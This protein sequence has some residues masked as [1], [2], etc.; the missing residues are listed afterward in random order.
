MNTAGD[1]GR[2]GM[3]TR[4]TTC[5]EW[6][7]LCALV[8][9]FVWQGFLPAWGHLNT[10][11]PNYY[12]AGKLFRGGYPLERLYD[13]VWIQR[14]KDHAGIVDPPLVGYVPL[15]P[16]SGLVVAPLSSLPPL[17]AKR[18]WL[19]INLL[20]LG[21]TGH[22]LHRMTR[23][24]PR[25]IAMM[26]FLAVLPLRNNF[27]FG[28]QYLLILFLLTAAAWFYSNKRTFASGSLLAVAASLKIYPV[29]FFLYFLR[30]RQWIALLG[31]TVT[32]LALA[33]LGVELFGFE[34]MR[35]FA[36]HVLPR[37][38]VG[39]S[40]DP[41]LVTL[42]TPPVL[43]R[44]LFVAEPELNPH[45]WFRAPMLFIA[46]QPIVQAL[47]LVPTLFSMAPRRAEA[48]REK[49]E[50]AGF[51]TL[52]LVSS[53]TA[54]YHFC[55]L[56]LAATLGTNYLRERGRTKQ[57]L[58]FVAI[59]GAICFPFYRFPFYRF[60]PESPAGWRIL[61]GFPRLY[62]LLAFWI[63]F[64]WILR[65][66]PSDRPRPRDLRERVSYGLA[67]GA[68]LIA[69]GISNLRHFERQFASYPARVEPKNE[70]LVATAPTIA[71]EDIFFDRMGSQGSVIDRTTVGLQVQT[72]HGADLFHPTVTD[73]SPDGWFELSSSSSKI[74]RFPRDAVALSVTTLPV[75][76][77]E[78]EQPVISRDGRWLAFLREQRGRGE[79]N[80]LD[81]RDLLSGRSSVAKEH[82]VAGAPHDVLDVGFFPDD[83]IVLAAFQDRRSR[84]Y[85]GDGVSERFVEIETAEPVR[86]PAVSP[87]GLWIVYSQEDRG[88][89][90]L[91]RM[92]LLSGDRSRLTDADCNSIQPAW[93]PDSKTLVYATDC[94][95]G[96]GHT[97]LSKIRAVP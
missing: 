7:L 89:W 43:L 66:G 10:D 36:T 60:V 22:L 64:L 28:Q 55:V 23:L 42:N 69:G 12:L 88:Q 61:L 5:L 46:L 63:V 6:V 35:V 17:E 75:E 9:I 32:S 11:F 83:R 95:R 71:G 97:A 41:Y 68:L 73:S 3:R 2:V 92:A 76:V 93:L 53:A 30:K 47:I 51:V 58:S 84:L 33:V 86:Y 74:V 94:G 27:K 82:E 39:E 91:W 19:I 81:R 52:L 79:L 37:A 8:L 29:L 26:V 50:W 96:L 87:D 38:L 72:P 21:A 24:S 57:C 77:D 48:E 1:A 54:T 4:C 59:Y 40:N 15:S 16:F 49:L 85:A 67:F 13:W 78:A 44:R 70:T 14:Q 25:R 56:I 45:P 80:L 18:C 90:Q 62:A 65:G 34:A 31:L 20:L